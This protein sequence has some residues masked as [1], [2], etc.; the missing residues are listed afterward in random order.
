M[1]GK[2]EPLL[3]WS[4]EVYAQVE[5][6]LSDTTIPSH[7][8]NDKHRLEL[9]ALT[10]EEVTLLKQSFRNFMTVKNIPNE[11]LLK[12]TCIDSWGIKTYLPHTDNLLWD[13][14]LAGRS[15]CV[16]YIYK[17]TN[18]KADFDS[19]NV[20][21]IC[22][23]NDFD[24]LPGDFEIAG[25]YHWPIWEASTQ[26]WKNPKYEESAEPRSV[27]ALRALKSIYL[28]ARLQTAEISV[29]KTDNIRQIVFSHTPMK[30]LDSFTVE[31]VV[32]YKYIKQDEKTLTTEIGIFWNNTEVSKSINHTSLIKELDIEVLLW[33]SDVFS[34]NFHK[35]GNTFFKHHLTEDK[36]FI[37]A[38]LSPGDIFSTP[39]ALAHFLNLR[40]DFWIGLT[41][42]YTPPGYWFKQ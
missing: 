21:D 4:L 27:N 17:Q 28:W 29:I 38:M 40:V 2:E 5:I 26:S 18:Y 23:L 22:N 24:S 42:R 14:D 20:I 37:T 41:P 36:T 34:E 35:A 30:I 25:S 7:S 11:R 31:G 3:I 12:L 19:I 33:V 16:E 13:F 6:R 32:I 1:C 39:N 15:G 10:S 8:A 9:P